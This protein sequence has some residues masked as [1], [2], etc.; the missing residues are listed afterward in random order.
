MR[1]AGRQGNLMKYARV[2]ILVTTIVAAASAAFA[3]DD[4]ASPKAAM[5]PFGMPSGEAAQPKPA[6]H[7]NMF[8]PGSASLVR[9]LS[10]EERAERQFLKDAAANARFEVEAARIV[11]G[12]STNQPLRTFATSLASGAGSRSA[13]LHRMLHM[14]G[15]APPML[16]N[17]QRKA[18]NSFARINGTRLDREFIVQVGQRSQQFDLQLYERGSAAVRD[19]SLKAWIDQSLPSLQEHL[20]MAD[21]AAPRD[22]K[23]A[24]APAHAMSATAHALPGGATQLIGANPPPMALSRPVAARSNGPSSP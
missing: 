18:L 20:E 19:P 2:C 14:R 6:V 17:D 15:M 3:Q 10:P 13:A 7:P 23:L 22:L 1:H 8:A 4:A 9:R 24:R 5:P 11:L 21:R 16:A 12:K